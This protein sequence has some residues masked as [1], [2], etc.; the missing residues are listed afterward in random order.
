MNKKMET[1]R[2]RNRRKGNGKGREG[3]E[4]EMGTVIDQ[5]GRK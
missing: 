2:Q 3:E 5:K 1:V 4:S